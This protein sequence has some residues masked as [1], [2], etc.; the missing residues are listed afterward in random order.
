M[1]GE[2][3]LNGTKTGFEKGFGMITNTIIQPHYHRYST[4]ELKSLYEKEKAEKKYEIL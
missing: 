3:V 1:R 4:G 2:T